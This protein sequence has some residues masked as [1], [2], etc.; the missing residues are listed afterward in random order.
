M[1]PMGKEWSALVMGRCDVVIADWP[2]LN[3]LVE[4]IEMFCLA[5]LI[6]G[7]PDPMYD[8]PRISKT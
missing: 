8:G 1:D 6:V 5:H 4:M 3:A 2:A 7:T